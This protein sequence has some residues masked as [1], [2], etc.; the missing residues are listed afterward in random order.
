M[1]GLEKLQARLGEINTKFDGTK[2]GVSERR[3]MM[4]K[5]DVSNSVDD[6]EKFIEESARAAGGLG[7]NGSETSPEHARRT[8]DIATVRQHECQFAL[9]V[10]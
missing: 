8:S 9:N 5:R 1:A 6:A 4:M 10:V 2:K 7:V 3:D